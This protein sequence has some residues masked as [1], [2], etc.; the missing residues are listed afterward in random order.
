MIC[1]EAVEAV[2]AYLEGAM[3]PRDRARFEVHLGGCPHCTAY[4]E[5][6]RTT[7]AIA[8]RLEPEDLPPAAQRELQAVW[9]AWTA[10]GP[11]A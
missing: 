9:E 4:L 3:R 10:E 1:R 11:V 7:I 5:Q 8:G 6:I 2:T